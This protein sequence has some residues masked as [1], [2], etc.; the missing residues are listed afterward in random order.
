M[1]PLARQL[2]VSIVS[3][4]IGIDSA[5]QPTKLPLAHTHTHT[6]RHGHLILKAGGPLYPARGEEWEW[7]TLGDP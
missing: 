2:Q 5:D 3:D 1:N 4:C 7:M 6:C